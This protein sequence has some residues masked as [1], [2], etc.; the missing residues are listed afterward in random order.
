LEKYKQ[1][2]QMDIES[3]EKDSK[4]KAVSKSQY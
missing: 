1:L 3:Y 4:I 2:L